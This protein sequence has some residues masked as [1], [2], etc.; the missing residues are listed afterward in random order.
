MPPQPQVEEVEELDEDLLTQVEVTG[1]VRESALD[2]AIADARKAHGEEGY[3][4]LVELY[5]RELEAVG[6]EAEKD[7]GRLAL[8]QHEVGELYEASGDEG[9]AVKSYAKAL[10]SDAT[11]KPN[12]WA[13]R[14]VFQRRA[15]WP[16]LLKLL[17]AE[18]RFARNE[19][20]KAELYV[21]KGQ[22]L[23]DR[24]NDVQQA[25]E[26]YWKAT[27]ADPNTLQAWSSLEKLCAKDGDMAALAKVLRGM[28][29]ATKEPARK[30]ALLLDL[31]RLQDNL[32]GGSLEQALE[33]C[34][35]AAAMGSGRALDE[36]ERLAEAA[37]KPDELS[38]A[39]DLRYQALLDRAHQATIAER[40][41][42]ND[43]AVALRRRQ[44]HLA[45]SQG[46]GQRAWDYLQSAAELRPDEPLTLRDL[47]ELAESLGRW[48]DLA[49]LYVRRAE[50]APEAL[51][52]ALQ[53]ERA[54]ALRRANQTADAEALENEVLV[55]V[56]GHL[57]LLVARER[58]AVTAA[59][60]ARLAALYV[61]EADLAR[62]TSGPTGVADARWAA[63]ALTAA[64]TVNEAHLGNDAEAIRLL[65]DAL[66]VEA[67]YRPAVDALERIYMRA[68][69]QVEL[70][71]LVE[72]EA[73]EAQAPARKQRL[74]ETLVALREV[75]LE[76]P[77]GAADAQRKLVELRPD[78]VRVR[79]RLIELARAAGRWSD[80]A[81]ELQKLAQTLPPDRSDAR[82]E[83]LLE[84]A[85]ILERRLED[86]EAAAAAYKEVLSLR[87]GEPRAVQSVE[88]ISRRRAAK[89]G[90][91]ERS[92]Q[93][94]DDL[95]L[96]L[97]RE[98]EA[99]LRP[100]RVSAVL[101]KLGD[102]HERERGNF[103]D[104][105]QT[106]RELLEKNPGHPAAL[107]GL[108]RATA[109]LDDPAKQAAAVEQLA[110]VLEG[111]ARGEALVAL[112][113]LYEDRLNQDDAADD[114][115]ARALGSS[116][117]VSHAVFGR[118]RV[119]A[120]KKDAA[121]L[122]K[123]LEGLQPFLGEDNP[124]ARSGLL[125]ERATMDRWAAELVSA[126]QLAREA[127]LAD[128]TSLM[129][130]LHLLRARAKDGQTAELGR[131]LGELATRVSD[132]ALKAALERRAALIGLASGAEDTPRES[133]ERLQRARQHGGGDAPVIVPLADV[134]TDP[135]VL[136]ARA[137][138]AEGASRVTWMVERAEALEA[139][140]RLAEAAA[141][142][143][144][145]LDLDPRH[146][147]AREIQRR[148]AEAGG[149][150]A[151]WARATVLL[152]N[153]LQ[154]AE[155]AAAL[156]QEAAAALDELG[157]REEAAVAYRCVLDR[158]PRD[159]NAFRRA[160]V[161]L[162]SLYDENKDPGPLV[163]LVSHR[164][165]HA[166]DA[167]D[168]VAL[169]LDRAEILVQEH[170]HD[171][172][173]RDLRAVLRDE[174]GHLVAMRQLAH[175]LGQRPITR[176]EA[177]RLYKRY[178][179]AEPDKQ[180]RRQGHLALAN[181]EEGSGRLEEAVK[182]LEAALESEP[183]ASEEERLAELLVRMRQWQ[184]AVQALRRLA[185]LTVDLGER[186]R[187][188]IRIASIY[189]D[190]FGDPKAAVESLIRALRAE[191]LEM[192][193]LGRLVTMSEGGHVVPLEL[194]EQLDR[195]VAKARGL[196]ETQPMAPQPY[197]YL[198]RLWAW[199]GDEDA[200]VF[201]AQAQS[202]TAG[203]A[204]PP[205]EGAHEP[206]RELS[207][208]GWERLLPPAAR[209]VALDI[210]RAAWEGALKLWGPE[211][212]SLGVAK[213]DRQNAKGI[214]MA[215]VP[216][217]KIARALGCTGYELYATRDAQ[218][219]AVVGGALVVGTQMADRLGPRTRFRAARALM[220]LRDRLGPVE[221]LDEA[222][223]AL[224]FAA[225]ARVAEVGR[226]AVLSVNEAKVE[227]RAKL[228]GKA[229]GRK[230][231]NALKSLGPRFAELNEPGQWQ[232]AI[233]EGAARTGLAVG[234]DL[235]GALAELNLAPKDPQ[236][237]SLY[238]FAVSEDMI[239]IR[240]EMGLRS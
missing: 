208:M 197:Q 19:A 196:Q 126:E 154:E 65:G 12:L 179:E 118:L 165:E 127:A 141:E 168:R 186:A 206:A 122:G 45:R 166:E 185:E 211:L 43:E 108:V 143:A 229:L 113:E 69:K 1:E 42:L 132:Q 36:L 92:P 80:A 119:A 93:A 39:L 6:Q 234:G 98:A 128:P 133:S 236:A 219:I 163:E 162:G 11:L 146:L 172:A 88:T 89:S 97:K 192:E 161:L 214:P 75:R 109:R 210:W 32:Q 62:G 136:G 223:L 215:W 169:N 227:E 173:E 33:L 217:D 138:L 139:E 220:L 13:I 37:G 17:D 205:R 233:L 171:G 25:R 94:W 155:R 57:G 174:P 3:R 188:E 142:V 14:R 59:D 144:R 21:E 240:R 4:R 103:A 153:E 212:A 110:E 24:L 218:K 180:K 15:L 58:A 83:L 28:A 81:D 145:A 46:D 2:L 157:L 191:P 67:S 41:G 149:D 40:L 152:A 111:D 27:E 7:K 232:K 189:N 193:A 23:E 90:P 96:A 115:F 26:C 51:R 125:D 91:H 225:C 164:L 52:T 170:D 150:R 222:E 200:R 5:E 184:N 195:A 151:G 9:S 183:R 104:A 156:Y 66:S 34:R 130:H 77:S 20:E 107:R 231:R 175:L 50:T 63:G 48:G 131:T 68:G 190:G 181:L 74:Y 158:T 117:A 177:I 85:E 38:R 82:A 53:L 159:G 167:P 8:Y 230:E 207:P 216:V 105:A 124:G 204:P 101:L 35:E 237:G 114:A 203:E 178:L 160:R 140:G 95:A 112:A 99:S 47:I 209:T 100:E 120:R 198:A 73:A 70:A 147:W 54:A 18:I 148:V 44:A 10:Q 16:N 137:Q 71:T 176:D 55:K 134:S 221:K 64:A 239:A 31:A 201:A 72:K 106:Y 61:S 79:L 213:G 182:H 121:A 116:N 202:L 87:P 129:P 187:V 235:E 84:R 76:D 29:S 228:L 60:W 226:P 224:F 86:L 30:V 135:E 238:T 199:R 78:D 49:Q 123:A 102:V 56:P 22:L 194:E